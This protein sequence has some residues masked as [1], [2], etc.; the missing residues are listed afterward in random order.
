MAMKPRSTG[1]SLPMRVWDGSTRLF[2]WTL[3]LV[4]VVS[5][6]SISVAD[7]PQA[8]L[9]MR[10]HVVSG[11][12]MLGLL[13]FRLMW[14][15]VGSDTARFVGFVKS[16]RAALHHLAE[17]RKREPDTQ[18]GHNAAGGYM[19]I[20]LLLLLVIQVGTGL[21]ANDDGATEGPLFRFISK[22]TSDLLSLLHGLNFNILMAAAG[23]HVAVIAVYAFLKGQNLVRPMVTGKK[24][25]P[26]ITRAP[27]MA[28]P[29]LAAACMAVAAGITVLVSRL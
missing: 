6:V 20:M 14:G 22:P 1:I 29:Y 21:G 23:L 2:H 13:L 8:G 16:P 25:L 28:S 5:Y 18:V 26:A 12:I 15:V 4:L 9:W 19:V 3:V 17:I 10:I 27:R 24:R 7:G 11:E